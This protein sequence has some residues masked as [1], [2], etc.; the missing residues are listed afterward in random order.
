[1]DAGTAW[2]RA[3]NGAVGDDKMVIEIVKNP[4]DNMLTAEELEFTELEHAMTKDV[5]RYD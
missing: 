2:I 3:D 1:V 5:I 4:N